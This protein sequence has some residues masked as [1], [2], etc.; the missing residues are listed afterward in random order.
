MA[1]VNNWF[2]K[3]AY[4]EHGISAKGLHWTS[5]QTQ[6][7][8]FEVITNSLEN[9][10]NR[11]LLDIGCGFGDYLIYLF[12]N[13][14]KIKDY[15]GIDIEEFMIDICKNRF[16][17]YKFLKCNILKDKI[18]IYDYLIC[19]GALNILEKNDFKKAIKNCF[20]NSNNA[21]IF[22]CL[23]KKSVHEMSIEE[24]ENYCKKLTNY[25]EIKSGY[26]DNDITFILKK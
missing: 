13:N 21:F 23:T 20:K 17:E 19:S 16:K 25:V 10:H 7:K 24:I 11:T 15:L 18:P 2:Y 3:K 4:N 8:R 26:L 5:K 9:I 14:I 1:S 6:Y 12:E 22:N